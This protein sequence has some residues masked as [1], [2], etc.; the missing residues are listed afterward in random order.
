MSIEK[1]EWEG[2]RVGGREREKEIGDNRERGGRGREGGMVVGCITLMALHPSLSST[3]PPRSV[4]VVP[5]PVS[6]VPA[7]AVAAGP[8]H[9]SSRHGLDLG[10]ICSFRA[11]LAAV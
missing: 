7:A 8:T 9:S 11:T 10:R 1:R 5:V 6:V 4:R 3:S 2:E